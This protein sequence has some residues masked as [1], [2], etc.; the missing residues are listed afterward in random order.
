MTSDYDN[1][2]EQSVE[3]DTV[4]K[5]LPHFYLIRRTACK[6]KDYKILPKLRKIL[7]SAKQKKKFSTA[8]AF[9]MRFKV[10]KF[11]DQKPVRVNASIRRPFGPQG[12]L[13]RRGGKGSAFF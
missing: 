2:S 10:A 6:Q 13:A 9:R 4:A 12:P 3:I 8:S 1:N 5:S 11:D 7:N